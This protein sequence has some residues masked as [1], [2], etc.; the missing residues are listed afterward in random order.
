M[1]VVGPIERVDRVRPEGVSRVLHVKSVT[2]HERIITIV[3]RG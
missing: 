1:W 2:R 3:L